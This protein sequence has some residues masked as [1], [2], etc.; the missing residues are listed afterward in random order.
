MSARYGPEHRALRR[1]LL[2][3]AYGRPC[4]RCGRPMLP[5]ERLDLDHADDAPGWNGLA[6]ARCNRRAGAVKTN[7]AR[8]AALR[9]QRTRRAELTVLEC[10]VAV[11]VSEDRR[12]TSLVTAARAAGKMF[13]VLEL[14]AYLDGT[15]TAVAEIGALVAAGPAVAAV[16]ID[17]HSQAA[18]LLRPL[19]EAGVEV[20]QPSTCDVVVANGV[21]R[22]E[23]AAGRLLHVA[24][25]A[26]E[27]A[28]RAAE[29]RPLA[30][31]Q[32]WDH[33]VATDVGPLRAATLALWGLLNA[34]SPE[35]Q[36]FFG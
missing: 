14:A 25:P 30:G 19:A 1:A 9:D 21:Y 31:A 15:A 33:R 23:L 20:V 24:H 18:T 36:V 13:P 4:A 12:H 17:P 26:L 34:P 5:G 29:L 22:D 8:A 3:D 28:V 11:A 32:T 7:R 35:L 27:A 6:H 10:A 16:V 2:K